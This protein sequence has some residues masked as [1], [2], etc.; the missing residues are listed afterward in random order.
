MAEKKSKS[1]K[2]K[3]RPVVLEDPSFFAGDM[4]GFVSLEVMEDYNLEELRGTD[5]EGPTRNKKAKEQPLM[6]NE[7]EKSDAM[8]LTKSEEKRKK[9]AQ[10]K[11]KKK[12][13][14]TK[15]AENEDKP[16]QQG[17]TSVDDGIVGDNQES[18][19]DTSA[20]DALGVPKEVQSALG[21]QGFTIPTPIQTLS[22]PPALFHHRDI[23]GAA[24]T[25]SGKT[26]A[27]GIPIL[28]HILQRKASQE[29]EGTNNN[30]GKDT[31][32]TST[33]VADN[34]TACRDEIRKP[35]L[36]LIMTPTRELALQIRNHLELAAKHTSL[37]IVTVIGGMAPQ[38][39]QRLLQKCPEI[40]VATPGRLW[41]L[42][43]EGEEHVSR[44]EELR[45]LVIDEADRMVE[46]GHFQELSSI[47]DLI[48]RPRDDEEASGT[49]KKRTLQKFIFSATLT[50]PKSFRRKGKEKKIS[51]GEAL[52]SLMDKV[53]LHKTSCKVID[54]TNT[55]GTV[56]TLTE[57]KISCSLDE[58]DLYLYYFLSRYPGRTLVFS[59]TVDCVRRLG[60]LFRLLDFDPWVLHASMQ[61]R[62]RLKNLDRFKSG[63]RGLLLATDVA[64]RG[65]DIPAVEHVIHYQV[66]KDPDLYIHRSGRTARAS[67]EGLSV[68]LVGPEEL[69]SYKKIMKTLNGGNDLDSF[70]VDVTYMSSIRK[71]ISLAK[72]IDKDEHKFKR[73]KSSNDWILASAKAMDIEVD[74]DLLEDLGDVR[75]KQERQG[76]LRQMKAELSGL[77]KAPLIPVGFSGKYPTKTGALIMPGLKAETNCDENVKVAV[78]D[79]KRKRKKK[80]AKM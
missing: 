37:K 10:L 40:I 16:E 32:K 68:V 33:T 78:E 52:V 72:Q 57:T 17:Q 3:W 38:K 23:I 48:H 15:K 59:N 34:S 49:V 35:L 45:Y 74:E 6:Q 27:F 67:R 9:A 76:K 75:E 31:A 24:E 29:T 13:K 63:S 54:V 28:T 11:K 30:E 71:R 69:G 1:N 53:G 66:P 46:Q 64:A 62:Q 51:K 43:S 73:K 19:V 55:R 65:L 14:K 18:M 12:R 25:G 56:E 39:Q 79:V 47:L 8:P 4:E 20:W 41:D 26:L 77:L 60:S 2:R 61:Q 70:P 22:I 7:Q 21:D 36:G 42:I 80:K 50:L 58:K 44:L 5:V